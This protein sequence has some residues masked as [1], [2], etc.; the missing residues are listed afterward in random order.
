V[1]KYFADNRPHF[2]RARLR[3][4]VVEKEG[5]AQELLSCIQEE[6]DEFADLVRQHSIAPRTKE[7]G[8]NVRVVPR[9]EL[10]AAMAAAVFAAKPGDVVGPFKVPDGYVLI[11]VEEL[12]LG[13]LDEPT[14]TAIRHQLF[15]RWVNDQLRTAKV[16]LKLEDAV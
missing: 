6:G 7:T 15:G 12:L 16:E 8:G 5:A 3:H 9:Q 10:P 13:Q 11:K 14:A 2:D 1:E 4:L